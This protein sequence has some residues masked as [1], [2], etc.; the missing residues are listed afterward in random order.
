MTI[1]PR[2]EEYKAEVFEN[3]KATL[4]EL[5]DC[6]LNSFYMDQL[7]ESPGF[8]HVLRMMANIDE[9]ADL[10]AELMNMVTAEYSRREYKLYL[11]LKLK[12][13]RTAI[14]ERFTSK[15]KDLTDHEFAMLYNE[16]ARH[17]PDIIGD[18]RVIAAVCQDHED[19]ELDTILTHL[20]DE[21]ANRRFYAVA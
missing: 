13:A 20:V 9:D 11:A 15:L 19:D 8:T 6:E 7:S 1:L 4:L 3:F 12:S 14:T 16:C 17:N 5:T 2:G 10:E 21:E 18:L